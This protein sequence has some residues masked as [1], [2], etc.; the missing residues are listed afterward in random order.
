MNHNQNY[1][2]N[3]SS[4][5]GIIVVQRTTSMKFGIFQSKKKQKNKI[6]TIKYET[7]SYS[8]SRR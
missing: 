1:G 7:Y 5:V 8:D 2:E 6:S 4:S 3:I